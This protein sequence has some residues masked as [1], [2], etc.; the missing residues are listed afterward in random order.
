MNISEFKSYDVISIDE[1]LIEK[2]PNCHTVCNLTAK[3][4]EEKINDFFIDVN[5]NLTITDD[6]NNIVF[7]G[8]IYS[9]DIKCGHVGYLKLTAYSSSIKTDSIKRKRVFQN[10]EKS[11]KKILDKTVK[12]SDDDTFSFKL[13]QDVEIDCPIVQDNE[14]NFEFIVRLASECGLYV[15]ADDSEKASFTISKGNRNS[16]GSQ[17]ME[18]TFTNHK[19]WKYDK[20]SQNMIGGIQL[21]TLNFFE[22]GAKISV[23][24]KSASGDYII[25]KWQL[26]KIHEVYTYEYLLYQSRQFPVPYIPPYPEYVRITAIVTDNDDPQG[27]GRIQVEFVDDEYKNMDSSS[28]DKL[29]IPYVTPYSA[30]KDGKSTGIVFIPDKNEAVDIIYS[31]KNFYACEC[32]RKRKN[33]EKTDF[34]NFDSDI[35]KPNEN[36]YIANIYNKQIS[37]TKD[38]LEIKSDENTIK[39]TKDFIELSV[40]DSTIKVT[41]DNINIKVD[42][43]NFDM[44]KDSIKIS[45]EGSNLVMKKDSITA[46]G[47]KKATLQASK[48]NIKGTTETVIS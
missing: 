39:L 5:K 38:E 6:D 40:K 37:F 43:S 9:V 33:G 35:Q 4:K 22:N 47:N 41:K 7:K 48:V 23:K 14:T 27:Y 24:D 20:V 16:S 31:H 1:L 2:M 32:L 36:K 12:D 46:N 8:C 25:Y 18:D 42:E 13:E 44:K 11:F 45:L 19:I 3:I 29:W 28:E 26:K 21:S 10:T 34:L 17:S 15:L 30:I